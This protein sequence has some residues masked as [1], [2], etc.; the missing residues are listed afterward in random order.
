M[1]TEHV[2]VARRRVIELVDEARGAVANL[3]LEE[4]SSRAPVYYLSPWFPLVGIR[5][6]FALN[7]ATCSL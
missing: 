3:T 2:R 4:A 5:P 7:R 6:H 1:T